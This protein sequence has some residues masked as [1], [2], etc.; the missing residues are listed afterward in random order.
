MYFPTLFATCTVFQREPTKYVSFSRCDANAV[1]TSRYLPDSSKSISNLFFCSTWLG[2]T[3][4]VPQIIQIFTRPHGSPKK[5][6]QQQKQ[7]EHSPNHDR[8]DLESIIDRLRESAY[9]RQQREEQEKNRKKAKEPPHPASDE[10]YY[11]EYYD[12]DYGVPQTDR[13]EKK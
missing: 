2:E 13:L 11:D 9:K 8:D 1:L 6:K 4:P 3:T 7:Q 5:K 12:Y 10:Y